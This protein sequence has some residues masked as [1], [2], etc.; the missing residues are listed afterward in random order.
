MEWCWEEPHSELAMPTA[1]SSGFPPLRLHCG[2]DGH[3]RPQSVY[4]A[5]GI[6]DDDF[7]GDALHDLR[8]VAGGIVGR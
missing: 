8:E 4:E 7:H 1:R 3:P 6:I 2:H 5:V